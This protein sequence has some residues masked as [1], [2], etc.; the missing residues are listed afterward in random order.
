VEGGGSGERTVIRFK[1]EIGRD[2]TLSVGQLVGSVVSASNGAAIAGAQVWFTYRDQDHSMRPVI[3]DADGHLSI[4]GL[5]AGGGVLHSQVIG[6]RADSI[7]IDQGLGVA[8]RFAL[9]VNP[10]RI[11]Y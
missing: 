8:V 11:Q 9:R 2:A 4:T 10:L 5:P 6:F 7:A 3:T 1:T